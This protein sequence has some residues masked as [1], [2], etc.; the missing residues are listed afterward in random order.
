MPAENTPAVEP[1]VR[2][3]NKRGHTITVG[4][5]KIPPQSFGTVPQSVA[6]AL[7][8]QW[9]AGVVEASVAQAEV[10]GAVAE[11]NALRE[12]VAALEKENAALKAASGVKR[13]G[14]Q[15][16]ADLV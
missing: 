2:V 6:Q 1:L 4:T 9:P 12:R 7:M 3:Y 15:A 13:G 8:K 5:A 10:G 16:G 11:A 14:R